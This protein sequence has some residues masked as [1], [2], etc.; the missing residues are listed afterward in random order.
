MQKQTWKSL[1]L[2]LIIKIFYKIDVS[3]NNT[4][5]FI[6]LE[7]FIK[8]EDDK[9]FI[10]ATVTPRLWFLTIPE[11]VQRYTVA[12]YI[13]EADEVKESFPWIYNP[14]QFANTSEITQGSMERENFSL[15][16]GGY[17]EMVYLC[18]I[19]ESVSPKVVF[20]YDT[21]YFLFWS[22]YLLRK[23]TVENLK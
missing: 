10:K 17:T 1:K 8:D 7:T 21:K 12:L 20:T 13:Q 23:R 9:E 6:D 14:P 19:F 4:G 15:T 2:F 11:F 3:F 22:E 18:A 5:R 16:Y